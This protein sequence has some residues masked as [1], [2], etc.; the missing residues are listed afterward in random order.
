MKHKL[1]R[2][3][4]HAHSVPRLNSIIFWE[5]SSGGGTRDLVPMYFKGRLTRNTDEG[6]RGDVKARPQH[7]G[8]GPYTAVYAPDTFVHAGG[9][10]IWPNG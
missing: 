7:L 8:P 5:R 9:S 2:R 3:Y 6:S 1:R 4:G 10:Y